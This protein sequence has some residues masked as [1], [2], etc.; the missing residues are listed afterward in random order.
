M[1]AGRYP[2]RLVSATQRTSA[3]GVEIVA[4]LDI[5]T[6]QPD[7]AAAPQRAFVTIR[8]PEAAPRVEIE[9]AW[10]DKSANRLP[11]ACW[12]TINPMVAEPDRWT[13]QKLDEPV[14]PLAVVRTATA[15]YMRSMARADTTD[16]TAR[17]RSQRSTPHSSPPE[18]PSASL[19]Q[20]AA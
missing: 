8:L 15:R 5:P 11:E 19:R 9:L 4:R 2:A 1:K 10:F 6:D 12:F 17:S 7:F 20:R 13:L 18:V 16:M 3:A 14:S